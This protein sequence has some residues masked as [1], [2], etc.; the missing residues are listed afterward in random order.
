M[1]RL[2]SYTIAPEQTSP[3]FKYTII[4]LALV[5]SCVLAAIPEPRGARAQ[6]SHI[7]VDVPFDFFID[8]EAAPAGKY[9]I[10]PNLASGFRGLRVRSKGGH[11]NH[12]V[13]TSRA[14]NDK[15]Q[16]LRVVFNVY[17]DQRFLSQV[18]WPGNMSGFQL[19]KCKAELALEEAAKRD[20]AAPQLRQTVVGE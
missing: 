15:P 19:S 5:C 4:Y 11:H 14:S 7:K 1:S 6:S 9:Y 3:V 16:P 10:S 18:F 20:K 8:G 17:G 12:R 13:N 2:A